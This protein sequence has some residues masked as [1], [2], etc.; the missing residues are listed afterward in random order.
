VLDN[1]PALIF[2]VGM[3]PVLPQA[4][5]QKRAELAREREALGARL[6]AV[7]SEIAALDYALSVLSPDWAPPPVSPL[8]RKSLLPRGAIAQGCLRF[9]RQHGEM[10]T[11]E[12]GKQLSEQHRLKFAN[13][14]AE[15]AFFSTVA[16]TLRRYEQ[17]SII[18]VVGHDK[19]TGVL[20]WRL[21]TGA[22][23]RL[24]VVGK[25]A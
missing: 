8:Y 2:N 19:G 23:G 9:L 17:K 15:Q 13:N 25:V 5:T 18:E 24:S 10:S 22:D 16:T 6:A 1:A 3:A 21:N 14:E 4:L 7:A 12:L 20:R 11:R